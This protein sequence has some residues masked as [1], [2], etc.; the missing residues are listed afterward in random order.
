MS[1]NF[2]PF[3]LI[4]AAVKDSNSENPCNFYTS[5]N[6]SHG[7][8]L[9][10]GS[11]VADGVVYS[12]DQQFIHEESGE[13]HLRGCL[14]LVKTCM[15]KCCDLGEA[16]VDGNCNKTEDPLVNPFNPPVYNN[17]DLLT[18][19]MANDSFGF[20]FQSVCGPADGYVLNPLNS[21][22]D[23]FLLQ[24]DGSILLP[25]DMSNYTM[26]Q[27]CIDAWIT[28][29]LTYDSS[30]WMTEYLAV[31]CYPDNEPDETYNLIYS[32]FPIGMMI[33]IP[34]LIVTF[35]VYAIIPEL[36]NL[37]GKSLLGY[38][39]G[40]ISGYIFLS[41]VQIQGR[42]LQS[43]TGLCISIAFI[44]YLS[45]MVSFFWLNVMCFDMWWT[46]RN[47]RALS[48]GRRASERRRFLIYSWYAWGTP[49]IL[50]SMCALMQFHPDIPEHHV[51]PQIGRSNCWFH[52][53]PAQMVYYF[54]PIMIII[55]SNLVMF[56]MTTFKI[57]SIKRE[58]AMLR[59]GDSARH[60]Q[61]DKNKQRFNLY[62]KL[63]LI[64]GLNWV[65]EWVSFFAD[66][67]S[68]LWMFTDF[69]NSIQ[70]IFIFI[71]F[72]WKKKTKNLVIARYRMLRYGSVVSRNTLSSQFHSSKTQSGSKKSVNA[73]IIRLSEL[74]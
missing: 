12:T 54:I 24:S 70:G 43:M 11:T 33:S 9:A 64:M 16:Y 7:I 58:T 48:G 23:E 5:V 15:R 50:T 56:A 67:D 52:D 55:I 45:F 63:F 17:T 49:L 57:I 51:R 30:N 47:M 4:M 31:V 74:R 59:T 3:L 22:E 10:N 65:A 28:K 40:L 61:F 34:F 25:F 66:G 53:R 41:V 72:V 38:V 20:V 2:L 68:Y 8:T 6:I 14:C 13:S 44:I 18:G 42:Y 71:L 21:E 26:M 37:H 29:P 32:L 60:Q 69:C 46:F 19:M 62:L 36:R 27:Y 1:Y 35:L 39:S 73:D